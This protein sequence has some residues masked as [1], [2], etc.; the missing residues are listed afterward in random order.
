MQ[1]KEVTVGAYEKFV[2]NTGYKTQAEKNK[3]CAY[4]LNGEPVWEANLNWR[5]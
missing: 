3:G 4:Y 5:K 1:S 2:A